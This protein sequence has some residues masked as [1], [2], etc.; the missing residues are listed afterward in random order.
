M[1]FLLAKVLSCAFGDTRHVD[2]DQLDAVS[3][4]VEYW[5]LGKPATF[6]AIRYVARAQRESGRLPEIWMLSPFHG[7]IVR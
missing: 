7:K 2:S 3:R 1:V 5:N 4:E 6:K